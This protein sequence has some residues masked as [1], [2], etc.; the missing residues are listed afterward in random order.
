MNPKSYLLGILTAF[1]AVA[2]TL[3]VIALAT[4]PTD[5]S[6]ATKQAAAYGV[7]IKWTHTAPCGILVGNPKSTG[8]AACY[9][10]SNP[11]TLYVSPQATN[12]KWIVNWELNNVIAPRTTK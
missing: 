4:R 6:E 12:V 7:T 9:S 10:A 3:G 1:V 11:N 5:Q 8:T 2:I